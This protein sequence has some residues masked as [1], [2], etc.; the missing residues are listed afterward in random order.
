MEKI[1]PPNLREV[2]RSS[3]GITFICSTGV[4]AGPRTPSESLRA[5][6]HDPA[7]RLQRIALMVALSDSDGVRG[8]VGTPVLQM[9]MIPVELR[10][11]SRRLGGFIFSICL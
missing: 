7:V 2:E 3:T 10:S 5:T 6:G 9:K 11:T 1:N 4:T 8:S